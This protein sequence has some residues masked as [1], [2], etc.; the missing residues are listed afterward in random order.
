MAEETDG[1]DEG[2][3]LADLADIDVSDIEEIRFID[4][5][6]GVY[7]WEVTEADLHE[8]EKDGERRFRIEFQIKVLEV[9]AVLEPNVDKESLLGKQHT[10]RFYIKPKESEEEVKKSIG[11]VRA[12]VA[13]IGCDNKGKLGDIVRNTKGHTFK[14][15]TVKQTDK[16]DKSRQYTRLKLEPAKKAA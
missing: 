10:E 4:L 14:A 5:P 12:F 8:E 13:D 9:F 7:D 2:F 11:R 6:A 3:S 16:N 15:P 1:L